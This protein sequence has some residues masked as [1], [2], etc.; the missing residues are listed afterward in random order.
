MTN[1]IATFFK[2]IISNHLAP[3]NV[4]SISCRKICRGCLHLFQLLTIKNLKRKKRKKKR[5]KEK[6]KERKT[7]ILK[8]ETFS[9]EKCSLEI[10]SKNLNGVTK[11]SK[12]F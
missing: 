6:K 4:F 7:E 2:K 5:T 12:F 8:I 9:N 10:I 3:I 1:Q 11:I